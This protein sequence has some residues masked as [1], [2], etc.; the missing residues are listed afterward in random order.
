M[1]KRLLTLLC[2]F[3]AGL[4]FGCSEGSKL[5][6][7]SSRPIVVSAIEPIEFFASKI[8]HPQCSTVTLIDSRQDIHNLQLTSRHLT[9][10]D[11]AQVYLSVGL[12]AETQLQKRL[13]QDANSPKIL[14]LHK[15]FS[16]FQ[17][18]DHHHHD[19][20]NELDPH[21]W[22]SPKTASKL[23]ST[24]SSFLCTSFPHHC[25]QFQ[26]R[27]AAMQNDIDSLE[28]K[29]QQMLDSLSIRTFIVYH[30]AYG[31]F[32]EHY[33]LKQI[34][35]EY[36]GKEPSIKH[37][38]SLID[39]IQ[40]TGSRFLIIGPQQNQSKMQSLAEKL[41]LSLK[42]I[43]PLTGD[44]FTLQNQLVDLLQQQDR[45]SSNSSQTSKQL[46]R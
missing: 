31:H 5:G 45:L 28:R 23:V 33:N 6:V 42:V 20:A 14:A 38:A 27:S 24:I 22:V 41:N 39:T 43:D 2:L 46:L 17:H 13:Q 44:Y 30:P 4:L 7:N 18:T 19:H 11:R 10:L 8:S 29:H 25:D 15:Q 36:Q 12:I 35:V 37:L 32:A 34:A 21:F 1:P 3:M 16:S 9:I 26:K 40:K